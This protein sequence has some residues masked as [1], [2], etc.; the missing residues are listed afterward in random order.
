M[1]LRHGYGFTADDIAMYGFDADRPIE[2][3]RPYLGH[4]TYW[5]AVRPAL[6][7]RTS[8][9]LTENKW[10]FYR[11]ASGYGLPVPRT[12]GLYDPD[13]GTTWTGEPLRT[14]AQLADLLNEW[15]PA[16][17]VFKPAGG[18][19]GRELVVLDDVDHAT[20]AA[21]SRG[22]GPTT[23]EAVIGRLERANER[24][25]PGWIVQEVV[26]QHPQWEVIAPWTSNSVRIVTLLTV[27]GDVQV[28][29]CVARFGR[30]GG[31]ADNWRR[32]GVAVQVDLRT[33]TLGEGLVRT[34]GG[35]AER[36]SRHP[37]S[38]VAFND[39]HVPDLEPALELCR[40]GARLF[41]GVRSLGWDVLPTPDGPVLLEAN[42]DWGL[43]IVQ[44]HT[45]GLLGRQPLREELARQGIA[46]PTGS[47]L[48]G[49]ATTGRRGLRKLTSRGG[50]DA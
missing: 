49:L 34:E 8:H 24:G 6:N 44:A 38:G 26:A 9:A 42:S 32:G 37:D 18:Q 48:D 14:R 19:S 35:A 27:G 1:R 30:R 16:G 43:A 33:G 46:L 11:L 23:L 4:L 3:A 5:R 41:P 50:S 29:D 15:R 28:L 21:L 47:V 40:R 7:A 2:Q 13:F 36:V 45:G 12:L 10:V 17:L 31:A 22:G 39:Q 25:Y 20:G